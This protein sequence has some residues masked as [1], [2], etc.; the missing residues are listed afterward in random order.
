[1]LKAV[2]R[3]FKAYKQLGVVLVAI[4]AGGLA[5][6]IGY[7]RVAHWI[8]GIT[9][10]VNVA[11]LLWG[12]I[13]DVREGTYGVDVLAAT[14]IITSVILHEYWAA[15]VIVLMLTGGEALEDYAERRA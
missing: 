5:D 13:Q 3:F 11:I 7:D 15:T 12:M 4:L 1:M 8:L 14:A 6:L 9:A 10:I 2:R